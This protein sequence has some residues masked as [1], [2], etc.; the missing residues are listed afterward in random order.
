MHVRR[1]SVQHSR[2]AADGRGADK[3]RSGPRRAAA[4][5][6]QQS[7]AAGHSPGQPAS[8]QRAA[9][10]SRAEPG[11]TAGAAGTQRAAPARQR[12]AGCRNR[13]GAGAFRYLIRRRAARNRGLQPPALPG[14]FPRRPRALTAA[15][16]GRAQEGRAPPEHPLRPPAA[17]S[18]RPRL[19][20]PPGSARARPHRLAAGTAAPTPP[21]PPYRATHRRPRFPSRRPRAPRSFSRL[22]ASAPQPGGSPSATAA[23]AAA[24]ARLTAAQR[25]QA[26]PPRDHASVG[27]AAPLSRRSGEWQVS[28]PMTAR[29]SPP[30]VV[31]RS[32]SPIPLLKGAAKRRGGCRGGWRWSL[33]DG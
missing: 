12:S 2:A 1:L 8:G 32:V 28:R 6:Q 20:S 24:T 26:P 29:C 13:G 21:P 19:P 4:R 23:S 11:G 14:R 15:S 31:A 25:A 27:A 18:G 33:S 9:V 30:R 17:P 7:P 3:R 22:P 10:P 5:A 16:E